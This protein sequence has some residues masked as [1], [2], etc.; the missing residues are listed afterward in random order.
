VLGKTVN[1]WVNCTFTDIAGQTS[2]MKNYIL[3]SCQL[4]LMGMRMN[5]TFNPNGKVTR[6]EFGTIL[7]RILYGD[8]YEWW[9]LY[10]TKHLDALKAAGIM[11]NIVNPESTKELRWYV[12]LMLMRAVK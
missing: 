7:S 9:S 1:T 8:R 10:Y 5:N 12:M 6:A 11:N 3:Q 4:G 2:E